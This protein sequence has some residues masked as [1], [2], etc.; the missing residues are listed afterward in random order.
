MILLTFGKREEIEKNV[1]E[2]EKLKK[3]Y[4]KTKF[5]VLNRQS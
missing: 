2:K 5:K 3:I 4:K 1:N